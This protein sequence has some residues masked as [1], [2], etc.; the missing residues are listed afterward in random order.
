MLDRET[1]SREVSDVAAS[2][3]MAPPVRLGI[4][5]R[6][7]ACQPQGSLRC[8]MRIVY[9]YSGCC[10]PGRTYYIRRDVVID[11][12]TALPKYCASSKPV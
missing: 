6:F 1:G 10:G 8:P 7:S 5:T 11:I 12:S 2:K 3:G 4:L 9:F